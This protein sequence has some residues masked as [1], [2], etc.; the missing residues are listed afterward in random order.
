M[1]H[2]Y[3]DVRGRTGRGGNYWRGL[4]QVQDQR[5]MP[6]PGLGC[7]IAQVLV[8]HPHF[9]NAALSRVYEI[10]EGGVRGHV[11]WY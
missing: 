9:I 3:P 8:P 1:Y 7:G 10:H 2:A 11:F 4:V 6:E 5:R